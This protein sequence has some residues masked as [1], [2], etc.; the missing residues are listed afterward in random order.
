MTPDQSRLFIADY[1]LRLGAYLARGHESGYD[2]VAGS[3]RFLFW[4][5]AHVDGGDTLRDYLARAGRAP[6]L[7]AG[8]TPADSRRSWKLRTTWKQGTRRTCG[9]SI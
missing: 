1:H 3:A 4:L 8:L 7:P 5:A 2:A 9:T 6:R